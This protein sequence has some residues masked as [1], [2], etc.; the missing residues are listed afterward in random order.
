MDYELDYHDVEIDDM[1]RRI[2]THYE[3][4]DINEPEDNSESKLCKPKL[5][6]D[7]GE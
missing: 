7:R 3:L 2:M 1:I 6:N 4:Y 5:N